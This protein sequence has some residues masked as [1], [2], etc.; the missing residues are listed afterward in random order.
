MDTWRFFT[1]MPKST[2]MDPFRQ[3]RLLFAEVRQSQWLALG[4]PIA[5]LATYGLFLALAFSP[6]PE[7]SIEALPTLE[8]MC[9]ILPPLGA[10]LWGYL[11]VGSVFERGRDILRVRDRHYLTKSVI[12]AAVPLLL[13][14]SASAGVTSLLVPEFS[15]EIMLLALRAMSWSLLCI[16][17]I[18]FTSYVFAA[19]FIGFAASLMLILFAYGIHL[20][21][22]VYNPSWLRPG[23]G[24]DSLNHALVIAVAGLLLLL[25]LF[26]WE[27]MQARL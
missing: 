9:V 14:V 15:T 12:R 6:N 7:V 27:R 19:A 2:G 3:T 20:G 24:A 1:G 23:D 10:A 11:C 21:W 16:V 5:I 17:M 8:E 18:A 26:I 13:L 25:M 22:L 4:A